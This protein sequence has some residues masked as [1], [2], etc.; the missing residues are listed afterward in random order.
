MKGVG[1]GQTF[2]DNRGSGRVNIS[3]G[4][5]GSKKSDPWTTLSCLR[6]TF[7]DLIRHAESLTQPDAR[8]LKKIWPDPLKI[9]IIYIGT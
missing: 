1:S 4:R 9:I 5:V 7:L 8:M 2:V 3:P 6:V